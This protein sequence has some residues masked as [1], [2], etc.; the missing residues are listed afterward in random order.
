MACVC[1]DVLCR[2]K[3]VAAVQA[4]LDKERADHDKTRE[5]VES[6]RGK[7]TELSNAKARAERLA[8]EV[9]ELKAARDEAKAW[10]AWHG[11]LPGTLHGVWCGGVGWGGPPTLLTRPTLPNLRPRPRRT[12]GTTRRSLRVCGRTSWMPG[13]HWTRRSATP[14]GPCKNST[15]SM[16]S[17]RPSGRCV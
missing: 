12:S 2:E 3:A 7:A 4:K 9:H 1:C 13:A 15:G 5:A 17:W 6:Q 8:A 14:R 10:H 16:R 11:P